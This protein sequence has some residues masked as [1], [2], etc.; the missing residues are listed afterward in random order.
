MGEGV[1]VR[2]AVGRRRLLVKL[3][4]KVVSR[5]TI[6]SLAQFP[7]KAGNKLAQSLARY[8]VKSASAFSNTGQSF[9]WEASVTQ[10]YAARSD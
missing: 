2:S 10:S 3:D 7:S 1:F 8:S 9:P 6:Y 4:L 5:A